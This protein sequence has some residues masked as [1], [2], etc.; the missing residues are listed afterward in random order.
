MYKGLIKKVIYQYKYEP[1]LT[2]LTPLLVDLFYEGII[3][4]E[5]AYEV[6]SHQPL[7]VPIALHHTK[8]R[9]RGYNQSQL[10]A[11]SLAKKCG[12]E[13]VDCLER[14][15]RTPTQTKLT[16]EER[17]QNVQGAFDLKTKYTQQIQGK[18]VVLIDD[19]MTSGAT[20]NSAA[21]VLKRNGAGKVWGMALCHEE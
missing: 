17:I 14:I 13:V 6:L 16:R 9:Q 18:E 10:L 3:Q 8:Y 20:F 4:H 7:F 11:K 2:S 15:K 1:Y 5:L 19:V 12:L 21:H